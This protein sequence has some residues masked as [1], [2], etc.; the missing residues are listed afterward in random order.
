ME[1]VEDGQIL[2]QGIGRS[3]QIIDTRN[4]DSIEEEECTTYH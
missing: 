1:Q 4:Y 3:V 2:K